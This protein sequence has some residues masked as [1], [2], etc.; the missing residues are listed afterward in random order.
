MLDDD[1]AWDEMN[2]YE[3][4]GV[5]FWFVVILGFIGLGIFL[6]MVIWFFIV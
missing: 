2:L 5:L 1:K 3:K 6:L 4:T